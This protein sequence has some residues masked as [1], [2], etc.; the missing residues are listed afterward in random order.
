MSNP[1]DRK[2][3]SEE[4]RNAESA[5]RAEDSIVA[6]EEHTDTSNHSAAG[7]DLPPE[8]AAVLGIEEYGEEGQKLKRS[9][10]ADDSYSAGDAA[11]GGDLYPEVAAVLGIEEFGDE[12]LKRSVMLDAAIETDATFL[13]DS[14]QRSTEKGAHETANGGLEEVKDEDTSNTFYDNGSDTPPPRGS[15]LSSDI[16]HVSSVR[17]VPMHRDES[18]EQSTIPEQISD[19]REAPMAQAVP[20]PM[21]DQP[22]S[23]TT[24]VLYH[25]VQ[26]LGNHVI[27][28]LSDMG[29]TGGLIQTLNEVKACRTIRFWLVDNSGSMLSPGGCEIRGASGQEPYE[30]KCTRWAELKGTLV[31]HAGLAGVLECHTV[32]RLIN[33]P[34]NVPNAQEFAVA[35]QAADMLTAESVKQANC[36]MNRVTPR[37]FTP[38][39]AH[40]KR[41]HESILAIRKTLENRCQQAVVVIA[42]DGLPTDEDGDSTDEAKNMFEKALKSLQP[43][44]VWLVFRL[45]TDDPDVMA[46]YNGIDQKVRKIVISFLNSLSVSGI[47]PLFPSA[48]RME[49][50]CDRRLRA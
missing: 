24:G 29:Y 4:K 50:R 19:F 26:P 33:A 7:G 9:V 23:C 46:Y 40:V 35:D 25:K 18:R 44:P 16:S 22:E 20:V 37:G 30:A 36:I 42:T 31:W 27:K 2:L 15:S 12:K 32:F 3:T 13:P 11:G 10:M 47:S 5:S 41:V 1:E 17:A 28:Q 45:C 14:V 8:V 39:T 6:D 34:E 43:L 48:A 38:L 49:C 21:E